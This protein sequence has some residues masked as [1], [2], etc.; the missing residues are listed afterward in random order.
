MTI[1]AIQVRIDQFHRWH[2]NQRKPIED[3]FVENPDFLDDPNM[4][5]DLVVGEFLLR[6]A[7]G[8]SPSLSEYVARFPAMADR[9]SALLA[10]FAD[11]AGADTPKFAD[12]SPEPHSNLDVKIPLHPTG[13][14]GYE[15]L[16]VLGRGGMGVAYQARHLKLN[17]IV[18]LK[19]VLAGVHAPAT[20]IDRFIAE[21]KAVAKLQHPNIVQVFDSGSHLGQPYMAIEFCAGGSLARQIDG[22]PWTP[23]RAAVVVQTLAGA[24]QVAHDKG[25]VHRDLKPANVLLTAD[26]TLKIGDFGLAKEL[27]AAD[28]TATGA[29]LGT[30]SYM[31][32]EQALGRGREVG[33]AA[34]IYALGGILYEMLTGRPPFKGTTPMETVIQVRDQEPVPV[35]QLQPGVPRDLETICHKCLMKNPQAR[36]R[37]A[38]A[39]AD[40]LRR[41]RAGEPI[42]ARPIRTFER[43]YKWSRRRPALAALIAVSVLGVVAM[44]AGGAYFTA[45]LG[46]QITR[47]E[48]AERD[49]NRR[50][51]EA[52]ESEADMLAY[53]RF[54]TEDVLAVAR[55]KDQEGGL[56]IDT[57][58]RQALDA[59]AG[60]IPERFEGRPRAE[61]KA[62]EGIGMTYL[63]VGEPAKA[64]EQLDRVFKLSV[65]LDGKFHPESL[66]CQDNLAGALRDAGRIQ[67]ALA[68]YESTLAARRSV[69]G[70]DHPQTLTT[71]NNLAG[72]YREIGK[73]ELALELYKKT[74][75]QRE[76]RMGP[77]HPDTLLSRHSL[78]FILDSLGRYDES[79]PLHREVYRRRRI[80]PGPNHADTLSTMHN[81]AYALR[82][83]G[84]P[85]EAIKLFEECLQRKRE[86]LGPN[87]PDTLTTMSVLG[88]SYRSVKRHSEAIALLEEVLKR[89]V[90][91]PGPEHPDT[92]FAFNNL[93]AAYRSVNRFADAA[94]LY[95][96]AVAGMRKVYG[97]KHNYTLTVMDNLAFA[98]RN[99]GRVDQALP[100][101]EEMHSVYVERDGMDHPDTLGVLND[102]AAA[103]SELGRDKEAVRRF[104]ECLHRRL[105][106]LGPNNPATMVS[107]NNLA[108]FYHKHGK[109]A[110]AK[111]LL[112]ELW[113][114]R[115]MVLGPNHEDAVFSTLTVAKLRQGSGEWAKAIPLLE[116]VIEK[117]R[118]NDGPDSITLLEALDPLGD[119]LM[120]MKQFLAAE[121]VCREILRL[122]ELHQPDSWQRFEA[123]T[124]LGESL[125]GQG[126]YAEAEAMLKQ[127]FDGLSKQSSQ[128]PA[129]RKDATLAS[130]AARLAALYDAWGK[131]AT[132][133][134]RK[135]P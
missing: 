2:R 32:P 60:R 85:E 112:E 125:T 111:A 128:I 12:H 131:K 43:M 31:A 65:Q 47:A 18:A 37:S 124:R 42:A 17:R 23:E 130:A 86:V 75:S 29:I 14:P 40:D 36:Y 102:L 103:Y 101:Y 100:V 118:M 51:D 53:S 8:E 106:I 70:E 134:E 87:N 93:A 54:L 56:G 3:Y 64:L 7:R 123:L 39:L 59:A 90:A 46:D 21:A 50:A 108:M 88:L 120:K 96:K 48:S 49:A 81:L 127:G 116:D 73:L 119:C 82:L 16:S 41:F 20:T 114:R 115:M 113:Q 80:Q 69:L 27:D 129:A 132:K 35:R 121:S 5:A 57:T 19:M 117:R 135:C 9:L 26:G 83:S 62:R 92:L 98:Y 94:P 78:A 74:L 133:S 13:I 4:A 34:D 10:A 91:G 1:R 61:L 63:Y 11:G 6:L 77:D 15:I 38:Q 33:P 68:L 45:R 126:K 22:T 55:P 97:V 122:R 24:M 58:V 30:P 104:E 71:A 110:E 84:K 44:V 67:D 89:G 95:E 72:V 79:I 28:Q 76:D 25:I 52:R 105:R 107:V 99:L 109:Q 66:R